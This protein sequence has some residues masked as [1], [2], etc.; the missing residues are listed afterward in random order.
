MPGTKKLR[1]LIVDDEP[2]A[3]Q[4]LEDMLLQ[5]E[6]VEIVGKAESGGEAVKAIRKLQP[7]LIFLDVQMPGRTGV[8]VVQEIGAENMPMVIFVTAYDQYALK[9]FDLAAIDYLLK[10]FDDERFE[11]AFTR[12]R[13]MHDLKEVNELRSRLSMLLQSPG[14]E[15]EESGEPARYLERIA[16]DMRGQVRIVP[17]EQIDYITASGAYAE[18]HVGEELYVIRERMQVLE[19]RLDPSCFFRLHRSAIVQMDRI[20]ALLYSAG[21]DYAVKL[22]G[23]KRLPMSRNRREALEERL[24]IEPRS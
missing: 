23:G 1:V 9:A 4:R 10:P 5:Q 16:V 15:P 21:G 8:E 6:A 12:A 17:V 22:K 11:M 3:R 2:L 14:S 19:E 20:E 7:D 18:L 24:G 13:Q